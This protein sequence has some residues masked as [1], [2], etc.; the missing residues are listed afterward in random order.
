MDDYTHV[1]DIPEPL[2]SQIVRQMPR[3]FAA[4][5]LRWVQV[6]SVWHNKKIW[7]WFKMSEHAY[8]PMPPN[9]CMICGKGP[10]DGLR[11]VRNHVGHK[12]RSLKALHDDIEIGR[13]DMA[14]TE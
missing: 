6:T 10:Q 7:Y 4:Y 2:R 3:A 5:P 14:C 12:H 1:S 8:V 11:F 9:Q 13:L